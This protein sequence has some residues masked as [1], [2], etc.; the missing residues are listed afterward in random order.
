MMESN[1]KPDIRYVYLACAWLIAHR[2]HFLSDIDGERVEELTDISSY[3]SDFE[4]WFC[5]NGYEIP[6]SCNV[7]ELSKILSEQLRISDKE[8]ELYALLTE[9]K[10]PKGGEEDVVSKAILIKL[11][12]GGSV[13]VKELFVFTTFLGIITKFTLDSIRI[14]DTVS[15]KSCYRI[16]P[17]F[18]KC[19]Y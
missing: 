15:F 13:K 7:K 14:Q 10:K 11:L 18:D 5:E 8:K 17:F 3:Y 16:E 6:W 4:S 12:A 1:I 19:S 2:G 9:G